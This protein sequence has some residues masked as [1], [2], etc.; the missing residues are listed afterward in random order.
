MLMP[1]QG[2]AAFAIVG[3]VCLVGGG[4]LLLRE[5]ALRRRGVRAYAVIVGQDEHFG[6]GRGGVTISN[7]SRSKGRETRRPWAISTGDAELVQSPIVEFTTADGRTVRTRSRVSSNV[8]SFVPGRVVSLSYDPDNPEEVAITG[9]GTGILWMFTLIGFVALAFAGVMVAVPGDTLQSAV[10][11]SIP[12]LLGGVFLGV[13][14]AG[15]GRVWS[16]RRRGVVTTGTVV[17]ETT[18][19]TREGLTL[20][21]PVVRFTVASGRHVEAPSERGTLRRRAETGQSVTIRY[22][23]ADPYRM[24]LAGDGARPLFWICTVVG[25]ATLAAAAAVMVFI[26]HS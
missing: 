17:G 24:L 12:L 15:I 25:L 10:W 16:L 20:H 1:W 13:G 14:C 23:P 26:V 4:R 18:S 19:S 3:L 9:Y 7:R 5:R 21:H 2:V 11:V 8:S 6:A 22:D